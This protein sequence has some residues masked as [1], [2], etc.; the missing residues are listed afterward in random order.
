MYRF[1]AAALA[2]VLSPSLAQAAPQLSPYAEIA[3]GWSGAGRLEARGVDSVLG[4]LAVRETTRSGWMAGALAGA[5]IGDS[6]V[7]VEAEAVYV[8]NRISSPDLDAAFGVPLNLR[9]T[10][11][12]ALA[13]LKLSAPAVSMG[14]GLRLI[15]YAVAGAGYGRNGVGILGDTYAGHGG[16]WQAKAGLELA[17]AGPFSLD[18]AYRFLRLPSFDTDKLGLKADMRTH[19][20]AVTLGVVYR[21]RAP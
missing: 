20:Q 4:P 15:P 12:G 7:S 2:A 14:P 21:F 10:A 3:G 1:V 8:R 17:G 19:V 13:N 16:M 11:A 5:R 6:P 9:A 18:L